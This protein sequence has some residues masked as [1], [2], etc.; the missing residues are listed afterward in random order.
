MKNLK[1]TFMEAGAIARIA[2]VLRDKKQIEFNEESFLEDSI[3]VVDYNMKIFVFEK[4][5][6]SF[7][8]AVVKRGFQNV[9]REGAYINFEKMEFLIFAKAVFEFCFF[10]MRKE[11][12]SIHNTEEITD[13]IIAAI[14]FVTLRIKINSILAVF[15]EVGA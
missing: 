9:Q 7:E 5:R 4:I 11:M 15:D 1:V 10:H 6:Q 8:D 12:E 3:Y 14:P 13:D 2:N